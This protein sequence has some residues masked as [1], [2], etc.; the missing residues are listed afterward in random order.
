[1]T[2]DLAFALTLAHLP[3]PPPVIDAVQEIE[4]EAST[5]MASAFRLRLGIARNDLG[6][7]TLLFEDIFRPLL[8]VG[9][10]LSNPLGVPEALINGYVSGQN[11]T[12]SDEPGS[13]VLEVT[14]MDVTMMMNLEEK[15]RPWPNLPDAAIATAIF[16]EHVVVP[17][18]Q[19][20][21]PTLV[22]PEGTRIQRGT[23]IRFLRLL[24]E[25]NGFECYVQ[26]EPLTGL[27]FGYFQPP[28]VFPGPPQAVLNVNCG[29]ETNVSDFK[30]TYDMVRPTMAFGAGIDVVTKT[31]QPALAPV[32]LQNPLGLE[33][34]LLRVLPPPLVR[35]ADTGLFS[36]AELQPALQAI[37]DRS[38]WAVIG[39]GTV[40]PSVGILR[41]GGIVNVRGPGRVYSG[42]Y[43]VTKV[44]HVINRD[45]HTQRF[46]ARRNAVGLTGTELFIDVA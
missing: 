6:D 41:P 8:P 35:P 40:G 4:V 18:V 27:D 44:W 12:F 11:V 37:V 5:E 32:A 10:R 42:S 20:T 22:E 25:R 21:T 1:M 46:Q 15:V 45:G 2:P 17:R 39:E 26:P 31:V 24:A 19:P 7:Y 34:A 3:A 33:P 9:I 13:A 36:T 29:A 30:I 43:Y 38:T 28:Q 23:D 14:G 16:G